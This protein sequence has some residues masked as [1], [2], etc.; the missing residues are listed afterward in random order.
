MTIFPTHI[1]ELLM[2][3]KNLRKYLD[4]FCGEKAGLYERFLQEVYLQ[5]FNPT[6]QSSSRTY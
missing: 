3:K 4:V 1:L 2:A 6:F 5:K